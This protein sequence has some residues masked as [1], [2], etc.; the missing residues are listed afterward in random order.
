V[1]ARSITILPGR[2]TGRRPIQPLTLAQDVLLEPDQVRARL[3]PKFVDQAFPNFLVY[4]KGVSLT[5]G[6]VKGHHSLTP[7]TLAKGVDS[8]KRLQVPDQLAVVA[9][10]ELGFNPTFDGG[11]P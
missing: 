4:P 9:K 5:S 10:H 1:L 3:E 8:R 6:P 2:N 7:K 11:E